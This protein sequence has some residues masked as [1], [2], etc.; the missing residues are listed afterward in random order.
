MAPN[1]AASKHEPIHDM[2]I[3]LS[4]SQMAEVPGC[5]KRT[6]LRISSNIRLFNS[7]KALPNK[8][9]EPQSITPAMLEARYDHLLETPDLYL[10][11]MA[12][13]LWDEFTDIQ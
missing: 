10:D 11:E 13:F 2:I 4:T 1:L 5:N 9:G 7:V 8:G 6:I 12:V 3:E